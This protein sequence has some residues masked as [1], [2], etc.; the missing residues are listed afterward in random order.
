MRSTNP[1]ELIRLV[2][3]RTK[4]EL[5]CLHFARDLRLGGA[6]LC[7][8]FAIWEDSIEDLVPLVLQRYDELE[9][10]EPVPVLSNESRWRALL[11]PAKFTYR[12]F[13]TLPRL[14][15]AGVALCAVVLEGEF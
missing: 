14:T 7:L 15:L 12:D 1:D 4:D 8:D 3:S 11:D 6:V 10:G 2:H 9:D 5:W 13:L